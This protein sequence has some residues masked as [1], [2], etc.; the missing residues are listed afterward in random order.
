MNLQTIPY[1]MNW[2]G[3]P[4]SVW[5]VADSRMERI[6]KND[7]V[8]FVDRILTNPVGVKDAESTAMTADTLLKQ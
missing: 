1:L 7:F 2:L 6:D 3:D 4:L 8:E 5:V